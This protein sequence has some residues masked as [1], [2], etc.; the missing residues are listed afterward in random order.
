MFLDLMSKMF[1]LKK[2]CYFDA[3]LSEKHFEKQPRSHSQIPSKWYGWDE[4][5]MDGGKSK[6]I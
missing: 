2:K 1:F 5:H 3:F 4:Y 6:D